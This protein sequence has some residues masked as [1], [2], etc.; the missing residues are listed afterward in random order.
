MQWKGRCVWA[1]LCKIS[2]RVERELASVC[3]L[4]VYGECVW[5][6]IECVSLGVMRWPWPL[7][8]ELQ[9]SSKTDF[10]D[11]RCWTCH[12]KWIISTKRREFRRCVW[13]RGTSTG[14]RWSRTRSRRSAA[15]WWEMELWV[16]PAWSSATPTTDT[17]LTTNRL[18]S[19]CFQVKAQVPPHTKHINSTRCLR[20]ANL[21]PTR[22]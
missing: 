5:E 22:L 16:K 18:L 11:F 3:V 1:K 8:P 13:I 2:P 17:R 4:S 21:Q 7:Y 10:S 20:H 15:C 14:T 9:W 19:T 6:K 12:P